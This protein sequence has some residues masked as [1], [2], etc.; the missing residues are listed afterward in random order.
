MEMFSMESALFSIGKFTL[1]KNPGSVM[2]MKR[3]LDRGW[4]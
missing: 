1:K 3:Y 2:D 4:T